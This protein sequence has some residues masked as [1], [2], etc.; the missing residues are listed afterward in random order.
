[1]INRRTAIAA[2][3]A[4]AA[5]ASLG[6]VQPAAADSRMFDAKSFAAAQAQGR[7]I[8]VDVWASWCPVCRKQQPVLE[9]L[10]KLP[11]FKS[12]VF[13]RV[14]FDKQKNVLRELNVRSQSTLIVFKGKREIDRSTG[15]TNPESV[16]A[17]LA[18]A[19]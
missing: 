4:F 13:L 17:L 19:L 3:T 12:Y 1:M 7:P 18:K 5:L 2:I 10:A 9:K 15:D 11:K 16:A 6:A 14:D 8:L